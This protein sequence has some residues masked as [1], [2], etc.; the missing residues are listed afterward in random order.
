VFAVI[1]ST[2]RAKQNLTNNHLILLAI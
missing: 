2:E 1:C